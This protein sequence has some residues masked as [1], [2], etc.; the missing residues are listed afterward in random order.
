[1][2][3]IPWGGSLV[4]RRCVIETS[5]WLEVLRSSLCED[6][7]LL[8]PLRRSGWRFRF[9][10]SLLAVDRDDGI[11]LRSLLRWLERQLLMARLHHPSWPLVM[12]HGLGT[13]ALLVVPVLG[14]VSLA[15]AGHG[16]GA[17]QLLMALVLYELGCGL[18]LM[19]IQAAVA[20]AIPLERQLPLGLWL[21]WLPLAQL[22]YGVAAL[23]ASWARQVEWSGVTYRL[24]Q[25]AVEAIRE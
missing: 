13:L 7:A 2:L 24:L 8:T 5:G 4:I 9:M 18:L 6:T 16:F 22:V 3:Q 10:P 23:R 19:G 17:L 12:L 21:R 25:H 1:V 20:S 14:V 11:S 15:L